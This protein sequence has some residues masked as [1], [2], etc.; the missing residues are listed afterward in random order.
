MSRYITSYDSDGYA[1][2]L[3][4]EENIRKEIAKKYGFDSY[5][6]FLNWE[7]TQIEWCQCEKP[8]TNWYYNN[9]KSCV[10]CQKPIKEKYN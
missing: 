5:I 4:Y 8:E 10:R 3:D 6:E 9:G 1:S 7:E 2:W